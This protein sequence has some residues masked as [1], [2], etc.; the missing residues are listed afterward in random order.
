M[1]DMKSLLL[2]WDLLHYIGILLFLASP[3]K[4]S[5]I[6][7]MVGL[8]WKRQWIIVRNIFMFLIW[9]SVVSIRWHSLAFTST[10][11]LFL[12]SPTIHHEILGRTLP[13]QCAWILNVI[14][15]PPSPNNSE[16]INSHRD[17]SNCYDP[18]ISIIV[19][20]K[21]ES[22]KTL[23]G[24]VESIIRTKR[25]AE[26]NLGIR[27]IR[28]VFADGGSKNIDEIRKQYSSVFDVI[29]IIEGGKLRGRHE[30]TVNER[31]DIIIAYDSDR[32]YDISNAYRHLEAF[33]GVKD[34][35]ASNNKVVPVVGTTHYVNSDGTLPFNGGNS[36][37]LREAYLKYPF[38]TNINEARWIWKEEEIEWRDKLAKCGLV[39][40]VQAT[41]SELDPIPLM[42]SLERVFNLKNSFSGGDNR[43]NLKENFLIV[44]CKI[45]LTLSMAG[46]VSFMLY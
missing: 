25:Y 23:K 19:C 40:S 37:Y 4:S 26:K 28:M 24:S 34:K 15:P 29:T 5:I 13:I 38:N 18:M 1:Q 8:L 30:A 33:I 6:S 27:H 2:V 11:I 43:S 10:L 22:M 44:V 41:Y 46:A 3:S 14:Y 21:N 20:N 7:I 39:I 17:N 31:S 16:I 36:A 35:N 32:N 12:W 45:T 42:S 9:W